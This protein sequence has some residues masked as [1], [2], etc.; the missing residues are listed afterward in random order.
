MDIDI[1][2]DSGHRNALAS[3]VSE[4][5]GGTASK[6]AS[7]AGSIPGKVG[8]PAASGEEA[9]MV[10][11]LLDIYRQ[12]LRVPLRKNRQ[13]SKGKWCTKERDIR[14]ANPVDVISRTFGRTISGRLCL[15]PEEW[16]LLYERGCLAIADDDE[17]L[18][19]NQDIW[20]LT[21]GDARMDLDSFRA[22]SYLRRLGYIAVKPCSEPLVDAEDC[23]ANRRRACRGGQAAACSSNVLGNGRMQAPMPC[24][25]YG[26]VFRGLLGHA[27]KPLAL[28]DPV[29]ASTS[30][31]LEPCGT[32]IFSV[33][34]PN[35]RYKK[36]S[37]GT[38]HYQMV[39]ISAKSRFPAPRE[40]ASWARLACQDCVVVGVSEPGNVGYLQVK[41]VETAAVAS[42]R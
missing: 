5:K 31:V 3:Y 30:T 10:S 23:S 18:L 22:Y 16:L 20:A 13:S 29:A 33:Y 37:P 34:K 36:S 8:S 27:P 4:T 26:D 38:P 19:S 41:P 15:R 9:Q 25:T 7:A 28:S 6:A 1:N 12:M 35:G 17:G 39:A 11:M 42:W 24:F 32:S 2:I 40:V 21:L 14:V